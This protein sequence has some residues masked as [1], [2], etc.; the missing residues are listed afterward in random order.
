LA[1]FREAMHKNNMQSK[2]MLNFRLVVLLC[3]AFLFQQVSFATEQNKIGLTSQHFGINQNKYF[4]KGNTEN[5]ELQLHLVAEAES[6]D[7]DDVHNEQVNCNKFISSN[8]N[9]TSVH[10]TDI[11]STLFLKLASTNQ[12]KVD[13]PFFILYHCWKSYLA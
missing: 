9:L 6:E 10:Y 4:E 13:L 11:I 2:K 3:I 5:Q 1:Y 12:H 8:Q 7:E